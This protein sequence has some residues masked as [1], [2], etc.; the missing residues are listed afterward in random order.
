MFI[1]PTPSHTPSSRNP[2][3]VEILRYVQSSN[4]FVADEQAKAERTSKKKKEKNEEKKKSS[5]PAVDI[6]G[7]TYQSKQEL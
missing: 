4:L 3:Y 2:L 1:G 5:N 6:Y 7:E